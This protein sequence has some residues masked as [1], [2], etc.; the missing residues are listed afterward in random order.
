M[1]RIAIDL[2]GGDFGP[3][4]TLPSAIHFFQLHPEHNGVFV[5]DPRA[6]KIVSGPLPANTQWVDAEPMGDIS[7]KPSRLMR[8]KGHSS[9][10]I[11]FQM[12]ENRDVDVVVSSEHTGVLLTLVTK[13]GKLHSLLTRPVL[14]SWLP[15]LGK[16]TVMLDLGASYSAS[17]DQILAYAAI[18]AGLLSNQPARPTL[19]L[20]NVGTE[21]FK[22]PLE[23][24]AADQLLKQWSSIDYRGFV[25]ANQVF[26][27][28]LDVIVCDGFTGN[29]VIK[30]S[31]GALDLTFSIIR[32][33][34]SQSW[35]RRLLGIWLKRQMTSSLKPLNPRHANG[36]VVAGSDLMVIKSHG[37]ADEVAFFAA[38]ERAAVV[39]NRQVTPAIWGELNRLIDD[40]ILV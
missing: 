4:V 18:G 13:H 27:G 30:A 32:Q 19:A 31:E 12:L 17:A 10:E 29:S 37:N 20:L 2:H 25:E 23:L 8:S 35:F 40:D 26:Q 33:S 16:P 39:S 34:L 24:R 6:R 3:S 22:G 36:A 38:I 15:T 7:Q 28:E 21:F 5:G 11:C 14:A 1:A 9:V